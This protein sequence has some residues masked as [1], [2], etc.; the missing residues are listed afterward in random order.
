VPAGNKKIMY[1][2]SSYSACQQFA[3]KNK[4]IYKIA[5]EGK[6]KAKKSTR[7][8]HTAPVDVSG[9]LLELSRSKVFAFKKVEDMLVR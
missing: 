2:I 5:R 1:K 7:S 3:K 8:D 6:A 9:L 4:N